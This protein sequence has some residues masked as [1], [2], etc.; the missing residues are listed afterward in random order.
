M[1]INN[2][3]ENTT[4]PH[5]GLVGFACDEGVR[6]NQGRVGAALAPNEIRT[7]LGTIPYHLQEA[8]IIDVGNVNCTDENLEE[9]QKQLGETVANLYHYGYS[10]LT[11]G[12]G[13][14]TFYG[15]YLGAR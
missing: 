7:Q 9:S 10:P 1:N 6:R 4:S 15:H 5:F 2:V 8:E 14:E 11:I 3:P 12:G 13:H